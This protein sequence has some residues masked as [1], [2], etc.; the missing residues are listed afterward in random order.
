M[1]Q[2][3]PTVTSEPVK[4]VLDRQ[5]LERVG[6]IF[7]EEDC[8]YIAVGDGRKIVV[9]IDRGEWSEITKMD[10]DLADVFQLFLP[11]EREGGGMSLAVVEKVLTSFHL[12]NAILSVLVEDLSSKGLKLSMEFIKNDLVGDTN[13]FPELS[14]VPKDIGDIK[15]L[16]ESLREFDT[17][18]TTSVE[19][20]VEGIVSSFNRE[21]TS[22]AKLLF[23][24][25]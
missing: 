24:F 4:L 10:I 19:A 11:E 2:E 21:V 5:Q 18:V 6:L 14:L 25:R 12:I 16:I 7:D 22:T 3:P 23:R 17:I 13:P 15:T 8:Y 20:S 1:N 9:T